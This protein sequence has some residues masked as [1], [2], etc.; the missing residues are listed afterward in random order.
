MDKVD[1]IRCGACGAFKPL[2]KAQLVVL[3][4][5]FDFDIDGKV[6]SQPGEVLWFCETCFR[7]VML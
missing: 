4:S 6:I 3:Q 1:I 7:S 5:R 2:A